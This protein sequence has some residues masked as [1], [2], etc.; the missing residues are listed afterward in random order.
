MRNDEC[1]IA[2]LCPCSVLFYENKNGTLFPM[3]NDRCYCF[4]NTIKAS[5]LFCF[6]DFFIR[7]K[8][9]NYSLYPF[10][11]PHIQPLFIHHS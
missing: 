10:E 6:K 7:Y 2:S 1:G 3:Y 8:N 5:L 11:V 4:G 9:C